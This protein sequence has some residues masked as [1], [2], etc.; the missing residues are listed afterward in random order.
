MKFHG[1]LVGPSASC[2]SRS[3][4]FTLIELLVVIA[5]IAILAG[6][7]LPAL[8]KA[9]SK[10]KATT[11]L[12]NMKQMGTASALYSD[13][14]DDKITKMFD[15][16]MNGAVSALMPPGVVIVTNT[17]A[18]NPAVYWVDL[19]RPYSGGTFKSS[20][21]AEFQ[22][23]GKGPASLGIGMGYPEVGIS[24]QPGPYNN[25]YSPPF[26][27]HDISR[28]AVTIYA[29]DCATVVAAS[30]TDPNADAWQESPSSGAQAAFFLTPQTTVSP[31]FTYPD[32]TRLIARHNGRANMIKMDGHIE[33]LRASDVGWQYPSGDSR[34]MWAK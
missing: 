27:T 30:L 11:C 15:N 22:H 31:Y 2:R 7:L 23:A 5:I 16:T 28:T 24:Y 32:Q 9:K 34:A 12:N 6:M 21:C 3:L 25:S 4:G 20:Q 33:A 8:A 1:V 13:S 18:G 10:S 14:N 29:A 26:R 17:I 19:L